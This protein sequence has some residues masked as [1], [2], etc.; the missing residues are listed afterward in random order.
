MKAVLFA[1]AALTATSTA[2][3]DLGMGLALNTEVKAYHKVDAETNHL[4]VEPELRWTSAA[5]PLSVYGEMPITMYETNHTS[6]DD[7][8]VVNILDDGNYPLLEL[9]AEYDINGNTMAYAETTYDFNAKDRG[10]IEV[11]V[12]W[13]F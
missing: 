12:A 5:G 9:G 2:A 11:G 10:E 13:T 7:W 8:N 6:G 1:V 4:T 3:A